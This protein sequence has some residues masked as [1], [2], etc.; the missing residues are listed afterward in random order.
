M[1]KLSILLVI[2]IFISGFI[3]EINNSI[4]FYQTLPRSDLSHYLAQQQQELENE[5]EL[6]QVKHDSNEDDCHK[7]NCHHSTEHC[8]HHCSGL[9]N[10]CF[11]GLDK[12]LNVSSYRYSNKGI[13]F[14]SNHYRD[15]YLRLQIKP[16]AFV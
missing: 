9:H 13:I 14:H 1:K 11:S 8:A 5:Y 6:V 7:S 2:I 12:I 10:L 4:A 16:P 3:T 15:P